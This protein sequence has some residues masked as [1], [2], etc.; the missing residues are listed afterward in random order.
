ML[1]EVSINPDSLPRRSFNNLDAYEPTPAEKQFLEEC[2][3]LQYVLP[4]RP[5]RF[6]T[7]PD[8]ALASLC[9]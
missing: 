9:P 7:M 6:F 1:F 8:R 2:D 5:R 4:T 3:I